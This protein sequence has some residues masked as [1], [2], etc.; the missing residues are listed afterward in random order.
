VGE[1][2]SNGNPSPSD[3]HIET[4]Q[5]TIRY[6]KSTADRVLRLGGDDEIKLFAFSDASYITTGNCKSRLGGCLFLGLNSGA[7]YSFSK[8]DS[9][10]AHSSTEAELRAIDIV[11]R[12]ACH[13][14]DILSFI[15]C[16]QNSPTI[17]FV[18]NRSAIDLCKTLKTTSNTR[19]INL[20]INYIRE[21][22][23][24][25]IISLQFIPTEDNVADIL[26]KPLP[27]KIF[28]R[29]SEKLLQGFNGKLFETVDINNN[30][31]KIE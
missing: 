29:H 8:N 6:L 3:R 14:R 27:D 21:C 19:H 24:N 15:G 28:S 30:I 26:T 17:I 7:I 16:T 18:D 25:R 10:V 23:N 31:S 12:T 9:V 1:I 2:S 20:I 4:A 11:T 5:K 22:I 13:I